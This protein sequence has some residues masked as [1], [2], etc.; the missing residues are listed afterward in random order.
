MKCYTYHLYSVAN[1]WVVV[2]F[3]GLI[4]TGMVGPCRLRSDRVARV[5]EMP[6]RGQES[7][8]KGRKKRKK[9]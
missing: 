5:K 4:P 9:E 2:S 6:R 8:G 3:N 7:K 1:Q